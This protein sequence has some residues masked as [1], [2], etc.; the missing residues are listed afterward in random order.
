MLT[1]K[2]TTPEQ[3]EKR[4]QQEQE[5]PTTAVKTARKEDQEKA[6]HEQQKA[7]VKEVEALTK[8]LLEKPGKKADDTKSKTGEPLDVEAEMQSMENLIS[9]G[10]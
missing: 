8:P 2:E 6:K 10:D 7:V 1:A 4:P 3:A 5:D 9:T